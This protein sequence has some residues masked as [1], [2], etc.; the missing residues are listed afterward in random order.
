[1]QAGPHAHARRHDAACAQVKV[2]LG[3]LSSEAGGWGSALQ[4]CS[5]ASELVEYVDALMD[6]IRS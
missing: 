1:M 4:L 2:A 5:R 6:V 3:F